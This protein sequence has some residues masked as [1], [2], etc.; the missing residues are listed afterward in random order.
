MIVYYKRLANAL[1]AIG[2]VLGA[3]LG[4]IHYK[5]RILGNESKIAVFV[6]ALFIFF[7]IILFRF[8]GAILATKKLKEVQAKLYRDAD[9][10][11]FLEAF[12]P[13]NDRV[14]HN[15]AEYANGQNWISYAR[16]ALGDLDG[17]W[18][19]VKDLKPNELKI[20]ALTT[21]A[22]IVNQKANIQILKRDYEAARFQIE[23]LKHLKELAEKRA[24]LLA[25]NL[26]QQIRVHEARIAA[27]MGDDSADI[28][29][30][31]EEI[32]YATNIIYKKEMQ[33]EVAEYFL[34]KG[35]EDKEKY[36]KAMEMLQDIV[37]ERKGLYT[38]DRAMKL[39]EHPEKLYQYTEDNDGFVVIK[40]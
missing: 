18:D 25:A 27:A 8:I 6:F 30:L 4:L 17:A 22:L 35:N 13:V 10:K 9:P 20:H 38:E 39:I 40:E 37:K 32:Q 29:Y 3:V 33:L 7:G 28:K 1:M 21:S 14:P 16:E 34:R 11:G 31:E 12:E 23:D 2:A 5:G 15:L 19:A 26:E 24:K 36:D